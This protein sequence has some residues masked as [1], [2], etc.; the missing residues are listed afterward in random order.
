MSHKP[1]T[2]PLELVPG[3]SHLYRRGAR[4]YFRMVVPEQLRR[5]VGKREL[6]ESL[7]TS[8][9]S[10]AKRLL[11]ERIYRAQIV[12]DVAKSRAEAIGGSFRR[13]LPWHTVIFPKP[14]PA[15]LPEWVKAP[16]RQTLPTE[17]PRP[18][19]LE[20]E[21]Q[22]QEMA[23][24]FFVQIEKASAR[25]WS[26]SRGT[27]TAE[28][29]QDLRETLSC[30][31]ESLEGN[32]RLHPSQYE[33]GRGSVR[34]FLEENNLTARADSPEIAMLARF[35][36]E[37]LIEHVRRTE[38]R[39]NGRPF[40]PYSALFADLSE[41]SPETPETPRLTL[42]R[43]CTLFL[44]ESAEAKKAPKTLFQHRVATK[45]L[46][47]CFGAETPAASIGRVQAKRFC[48]VLENLPLNRTQ[49]YPGLSV[50]ESIEA[51]SKAGDSQRMGHTTRR[52]R[53]FSAFAVFEYGTRTLRE[54]ADNPFDDKSLK[55]RCTPPPEHTDEAKEKR[56]AFSV[57]ELN[58]IFSSPPFTTTLPPADRPA[59][60]W[61]P[62]IALFHGMRQTEICQ[63][64]T[65]D[66][67]E[68]EGGLYFDVRP[69]EGKRLKNTASR[70]SVPL[71]PQLLAMG[72]ACYVEARRGDVHSK[73]LFP[74][75]APNR[76]DDSYGVKMSRWFA[77]FLAKIPG[78]PILATFHSFRNCFTVAA[79]KAGVPED[80]INRICGWSSGSRQQ[81]DYA[82]DKFLAEHAEE[83][84]K[85][86][87]AGL[88]LPAFTE[89][90]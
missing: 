36:R 82:R 83:I 76:P 67:A 50:E 63:L 64:H 43:L 2:K 49:R 87:Y 72:F 61:V 15:D 60:F 10:E 20:S 21:E 44:A 78:P 40:Q 55:R 4:Y 18:L 68:W 28:E 19:T 22:A 65:A 25:R 59:R 39:I 29:L 23:R 90:K 13:A 89:T 8:N 69:G 6:V 41:R 3:A 27:F 86:Q 12:L 58:R 56:P 53:F 79:Q 52:N 75:L 85:V 11:P 30:D 71:H 47:D 73:A 42:E 26:E 37:A 32:P 77:S 46:I 54:L 48:E 35:F 66:V 62:L 38:D 7:N 14:L 34:G 5:I 1:A 70:R 84:A 88:Q 74:E 16:D 81:R 57:A 17:R 33:D 45:L 9:F 24:R 51:A 31:R 80:R